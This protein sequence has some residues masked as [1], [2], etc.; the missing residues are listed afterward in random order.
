MK[1]ST[2]TSVLV[3]Y[4]LMDAVD[5]V[6]KTGFDGVDIWCG[7]PHLY[8]HDFS[9]ETISVMGEKIKKSGLKIVSIMPAF[10]RYPYS[11]SSSLEAVCRDSIGYMKDCIDNAILI[12]ADN[13][14]VVPMSRLLNQTPSEARRLFV[15]NLAEVCEYAEQKHIRLDVE[16]L[17]P[18][19]CNFIMNT[20]DAIEILHDLGSDNLGLVLD[21]GEM[22]LSGE[23]FDSAFEYAGDKIRNIHIN[24]NDGVNDANLIPGEGSFNFYALGDTLKKYNYNGYLSLELGYHYSSEP[25]TVLS[26]AITATR[27]IFSSN[28]LDAGHSREQ[29]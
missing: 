11:L 15:K 8:R 22:N 25:V 24:D 6:V 3:N 12:G 13:V 16:V 2:V 1:I 17:N 10:Y 5:V 26:K 4:T 14:L 23:S 27:N 18:L 21:T 9:E 19:S 29:Q 7:R 28:R 20:Q